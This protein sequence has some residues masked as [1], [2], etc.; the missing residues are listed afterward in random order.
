[1]TNYY[2]LADMQ[3]EGRLMATGRNDI[4]LKELKKSLLGYLSG[5][6]DDNELKKLKKIPMKELCAIYEFKIVKRDKKFQE[7]Y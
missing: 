7:N 6:H 5:D 4:S 1:M 3:N 2:A